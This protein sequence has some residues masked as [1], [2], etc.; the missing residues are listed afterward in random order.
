MKRVIR[1][2]AIIL[3]LVF[4][5]VLAACGKKKEPDKVVDKSA[6]EIN[7]AIKN[8]WGEDGYGANTE[9]E[10]DWLINS[11]GIDLDKVDDYYAAQNAISSINPDT[12]IILKVKDGYAKE[13][14]DALNKVYANAVNYGT[15]YPFA[16]A[17]I[18][19]A[20]LYNEGNY[21]IYVIGGN[22]Y[23]GDS[24][25]EEVKFTIAEYEKVDKALEEIF[26]KKLENLAIAPEVD[27]NGGGGLI[28]P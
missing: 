4:V 27:N 13:A 2:I 8:A 25:E 6:A 3:A 23:T 5:F 7:E 14:I 20:R 15:L 18:M 16:V 17:K 28:I 12:V 1:S 9:I 11:F 19:N 24:E 10:R 26:G 21:V 22:A